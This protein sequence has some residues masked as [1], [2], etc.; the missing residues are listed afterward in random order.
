[1]KLIAIMLLALLLTAGSLPLTTVSDTLVNNAGL[2]FSGILLVSWPAYSVSGQTVQAGSMSVFVQG[3][4]LSLKLV[5]T[6]QMT[7]AGPCVY[8]A[9][10]NGAMTTWVVPTSAS[11]L[12]LSQVTASPLTGIGYIQLGSAA[13]TP[14]GVTGLGVT[15]VSSGSYMQIQVQNLSGTTGSSDLVATA[16]DGN[17][18]AHY[19][20]LGI[21][22]AGGASSPF[23]NPHAGYLYLQDSEF[24]IGALGASSPAI[25]FWLGSTPAQVATISMAGIAAQ[26]LAGS[27]TGWAAAVGAAAGA[28]PGTPACVASHVCDSLSGQIGLTM[29]TATTTTG[30]ILTVTLNGTARVN[31]PNCVVEAWL[32]ASPYT[33]LA[34]SPTVT[35]SSV[36]FQV[37]GTAAAT[38]TAYTFSYVCGGQ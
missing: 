27:S 3:G 30:V 22:S 32:S 28:S 19:I 18:S 34:V 12:T 15:G 1:M 35:T 5:P 7:C 9:Q 29:G 23:T 25:N 36:S 2:P 16:N 21:N 20:D 11:T 26:A 14:A 8:T 24:D 6:D 33:P 13:Y 37:T 10:W 4:V 17:D 38:S 31:L